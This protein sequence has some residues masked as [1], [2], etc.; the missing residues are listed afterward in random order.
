MRAEISA[1]ERQTPASLWERRTGDHLTQFP[2][3]PPYT[4]VTRPEP[5]GPRRGS[6]VS[7]LGGGGSP[8]SGSVGARPV[9]GRDRAQP[10]TPLGKPRRPL[11]FPRPP[12][13]VWPALRAAPGQGRGAEGG[14]A[15][16]GG[17]GRVRAGGAGTVPRGGEGAVG[18]PRA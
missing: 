3:G 8:R 1:R 11:T 17:S 4:T 2:P 6:R 16:L 5:L 13:R 12:Q 14:G 18:S 7:P 10:P 9:P 15:G